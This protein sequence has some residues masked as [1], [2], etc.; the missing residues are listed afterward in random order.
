MQA[1]ISAILGANTAQC[2]SVPSQTPSYGTVRRSGSCSPMRDLPT[3][4]GGMILVCW[5]PPEKAFRRKKRVRGKAGGTNIL[6]DW[7]ALHGECLF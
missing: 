1:A 5:R 4:D 7:S 3:A 2:S 6:C